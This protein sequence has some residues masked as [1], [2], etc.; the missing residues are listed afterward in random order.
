[1]AKAISIKL[2]GTGRNT[3]VRIDGD[4]VRVV[5]LRIYVPSHMSP[6]EI[7]LTYFPKPGLDEVTFEGFLSD[8]SADG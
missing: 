7:S 1:M 2:G 4:L 3:E 8:R 6:T 5:S